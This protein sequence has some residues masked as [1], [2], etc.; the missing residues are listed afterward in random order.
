MIEEKLGLS[1]YLE[2][3][4][5][6][7]NTGHRKPEPEAYLGPARTLGLAPSECLFVDDRP[8][9]VEGAI[10]AGMPGVVFTDAVTLRADLA[11]HGLL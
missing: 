4:F 6:S 11:R 1:R 2:W 10:A 5:V 8:V 7:C 3:S 9:N